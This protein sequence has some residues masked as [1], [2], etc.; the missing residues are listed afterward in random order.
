[1]KIIKLKLDAAYGINKEVE[2]K[3]EA[4]EE[5]GVDAITHKPVM[6]A[7][8]GHIKQIRLEPDEHYFEVSIEGE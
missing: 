1:M 5:V 6:S 2:E 7:V 4:G 8:S 3:V